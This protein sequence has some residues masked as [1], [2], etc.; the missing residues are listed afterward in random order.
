MLHHAWLALLSGA[1]AIGMLASVGGA[2]QGLAFVM[3][4][5]VLAR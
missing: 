1:A 5:E 2:M 4:A 3:L